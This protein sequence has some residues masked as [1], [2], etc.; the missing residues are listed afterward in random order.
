MATYMSFIRPISLG[1]YR[2]LQEPCELS[3]TPQPFWHKF[4]LKLWLDILGL[5]WNFPTE[6]KDV[7]PV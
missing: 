6:G 4:K 2:V 3:C 5:F 7:Q 1:L